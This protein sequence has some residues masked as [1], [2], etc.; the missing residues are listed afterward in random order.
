[1][2]QMEES[3][4]TLSKLLYQNYTG[5]FRRLLGYGGLEI[6]N[7]TISLAKER[8]SILRVE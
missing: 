6:E 7:G 2:T 8:N 3:L 1:M 5:V 4:S